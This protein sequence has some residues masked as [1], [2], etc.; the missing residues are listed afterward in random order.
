MSIHPPD[1]FEPPA[2]IPAVAAAPSVAAAVVT[3]STKRV[4]PVGEQVVNSSPDVPSKKSKGAQ[5][6]DDNKTRGL[7]H[8]SLRVCK[9]VEQKQ[10]T[11]YNEVADELVLE[12]MSNRESDDSDTDVQSKDSNN[13]GHSGRK[14]NSSIDEKNIRRRVYDALNVLMAMEIITK[15]KKDII[16]QGF[17]NTTNDDVEALQKER[18]VLVKKIESKK[19]CF[20]ELLIQNICFRNLVKR[21]RAQEIISSS[22]MDTKTSSSPVKDPLKIPL[23][24]IVVQTSPKARVQ[25]EMNE[26][27]TDVVFDFDMPFQI[28]DDNEVLQRSGLFRTSFDDLVSFL[29]KD[30]V[31]YCSTNNFLDS[32]V[33]PK[34]QLP[35]YL[36]GRIPQYHCQM[37]SPDQGNAIGDTKS[38]QFRS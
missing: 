14:A 12:L 1:Q 31:Q 18:D 38:N 21:N 35:D 4:A 32:I 2:D 26:D 24:F 10:R 29:P 13:K 16:W 17:P 15:N 37:T 27:R 3:P 28:H 33:V 22:S 36:R 19:E 20:H 7:R 34:E 6:V 25:C 23:P 9:K 11:T 8:F 5:P 30:M